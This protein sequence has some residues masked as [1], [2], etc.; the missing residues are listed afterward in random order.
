MHDTLLGDL[1]SYKDEIDKNKK[2][3]ASRDKPIER[4]RDSLIKKVDAK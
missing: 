4:P 3:L 2:D 1:K